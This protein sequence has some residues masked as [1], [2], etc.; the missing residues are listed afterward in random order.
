MGN[1]QRRSMTNGNGNGNGNDNRN[2]N[3]NNNGNALFS[4]ARGALGQ[5]QPGKNPGFGYAREE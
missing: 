5:P 1:G 2:D 3:S 4:N